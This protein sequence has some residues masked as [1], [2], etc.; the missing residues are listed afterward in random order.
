MQITIFNISK[1]WAHET[2]EKCLNLA[3]IIATDHITWPGDCEKAANATAFHKTTRTYLVPLMG[4]ILD[5][6]NQQRIWTKRA[7]SKSMEEGV[8]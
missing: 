3:C 4:A 5:Y 8:L 2:M 6:R 7:H 1:S